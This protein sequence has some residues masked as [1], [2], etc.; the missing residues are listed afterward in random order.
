MAD[1]A[2]ELLGSEKRISLIAEDA[3]SRSRGRVSHR[4]SSAARAVRAVRDKAGKSTRRF[5]INA[6]RVVLDGPRWRWFPDD[7]RSVSDSIQRMLGGTSQ[8]LICL[9]ADIA[10][11]VDRNQR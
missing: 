2:W 9:F 3:H 8:T 5:Q 6:L 11:L 4:H 10:E 7:A 1:W